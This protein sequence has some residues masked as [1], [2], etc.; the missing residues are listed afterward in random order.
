M[1][2]ENLVRANI[3]TLLKM[4]SEREDELDNIDK[5]IHEE[6]MRLLLITRGI[7][8][9]TVVRDHHGDRFRIGVITFWNYDDSDRGARANF[10]GFQIKKDGSDGKALRHIYEYN[11]T[12]I[13]KE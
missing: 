2:N 4:K 1:S 8:I 9:G 5:Q 3:K 7:K 10:K 11:G 6:R 12:L 13:V